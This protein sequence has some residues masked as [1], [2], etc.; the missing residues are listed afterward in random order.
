MAGTETTVRNAVVSIIRGIKATL[1]LDSDS[2]IHD[3]LLGD[4]QEEE[5]LAYL[6]N[7]VSSAP[8]LRSIGVQVTASD[9]LFYV[10][11]ALTTAR[12]GYTI[13]IQLYYAPE[14]AG[15]GMNRM[16]DAARAI[17]SALQSAGTKLNDT[18]QRVVEVEELQREVVTAPEA[19]AENEMIL[20][21]MNVIAEDN[22]ATF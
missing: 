8:L 6:M 9:N 13:T 16:I 18:V 19:V 11:S 3:H 17:R 21:T 5:K 14:T 1:G 2:A 12:R 7:N 15:A 10:S 22:Y 20:G 4:L